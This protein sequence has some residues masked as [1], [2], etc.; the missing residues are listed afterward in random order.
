MF[1]LT[2]AKKFHSL[3]DV[4]NGRYVNICLQFNASEVGILVRRSSVYTSLN[5]TSLSEE[6]SKSESRNSRLYLCHNVWSISY[7]HFHSRLVFAE[8]SSRFRLLMLSPSNRARLFLYTKIITPRSVKC[9]KP[10]FLLCHLPNYFKSYLL[11][12]LRLTPA[13]PRHIRWKTK[14]CPEKLSFCSS[15]AFM[16]K[17]RDGSVG[18]YRSLILS[19]LSG[20]QP[21]DYSMAQHCI[22]RTWLDFSH[23]ANN[24]GFGIYASIRMCHS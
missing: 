13:D 14:F 16:M 21:L 17:V 20:V 12:W 24:L 19:A 9:F 10:A 3:N 18:I 15:E 1:S 4:L 23:E 2:L 7:I 8:L 22:Q 6:N 5:L 11:V